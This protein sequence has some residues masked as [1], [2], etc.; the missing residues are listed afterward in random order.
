[1]T[2]IEKIVTSWIIPEQDDRVKSEGSDEFVGDFFDEVEVSETCKDS[3]VESIQLRS[4]SYNL[5]TGN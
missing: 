4:T 5:Y 1:M 2:V 3:E